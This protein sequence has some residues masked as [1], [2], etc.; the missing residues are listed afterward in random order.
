ML[1]NLPVW[2]KNHYNVCLE[3]NLFEG[4]KV[5]EIGGYTQV[6]VA[7]F[8]K[9][10]S[11]DC[12]DPAF[13]KGEIV[14]QKVSKIKLPVE[15]YITDKKF[16]LIFATNS[17]EHIQNFDVAIEKMYDLLNEGGYLSALL[18]PIWSC[19]KGHH[20]WTVQPNGTS[21]NFN[22]L[23][24]DWAHLKYKE[25][26]LKNILL[27][28]YEQSTANEL[29]RQMTNWDF[30]NHMFYDDYVEAINRTNFNIIEFRDWHTSKYPDEE[31]QKEL[32]EKYKKHNFST[33][34]IKML[35][36]K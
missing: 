13:D 21:V 35:L 3:K 24:M 34:S 36:K 5:L 30:L 8:L 32:E 4:K 17:F 26:E 27:N 10:K 22:N 1:E 25:R 28:R 20:V 29:L 12:I 31:L 9:V 15:E 18:G 14:S 23:D 7:D 11:W 2:Q 16:D 33:V 6:E 19:Y